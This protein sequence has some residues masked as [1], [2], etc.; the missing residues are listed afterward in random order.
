MHSAQYDRE[1]DMR[2]EPEGISVDSRLHQ[3]SFTVYAKLQYLVSH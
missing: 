2:T 3:N 1:R